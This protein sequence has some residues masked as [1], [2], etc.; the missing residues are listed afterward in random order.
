MGANK[1]WLALTDRAITEVV[2][3]GLLHHVAEDQ[4]LDGRSVSVDG[5]PLINFSL[6]SYLGLEMDARLK[7]GVIDAVMRYGTQFSASRAYLAVAMY[8]ELESLL[9][10]IFGGHVLVT[11]TTTLGHIA[12][13][14]VIVDQN[15]AVILD[16]MVHNSVQT[17]AAL[18]SGRG[19]HV[20]NIPHSAMDLLEE[21]IIE[22][23]K[24]HD[25]VWYLA[26]GVYSMFG[27]VAPLPAL[28][29]LLDRYPQ[30]HL[31]CDD[32]H[33]M[34]WSGKHGCGYA[35]SVQP[36]RDRMI[37]TTSLNKAFSA[38]GGAL[39]FPDA[40]MRR[41][42]RTCGGPMVFSGPIQPPMLGAA[43]ASARIHLSDDIHP[44]QQALKER[45]RHWNRLVQRYGLPQAVNNETPIQFV[46]IGPSKATY[47]ATKRVMEE[48]FLTNVSAFPIVPLRQAG[49]RLT[50]TLHHTFEDIERLAQSLACNLELVGAL[51]SVLEDS[52]QGVVAPTSGVAAPS[53]EPEITVAAA[54]APLPT[55]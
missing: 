45:I 24:T 35:L 4:V 55:R 16:Q 39:I 11:P 50:L 5:K 41:K 29:D 54:S 3:L 43:L 15:D 42:V 49:I 12:A 2:E 34:S 27:D 13:L 19:T 32:A 46:K 17:A 7:Q 37:V 47:A 23:S 26:D 36:L 28:H 20:E 51:D 6:C 1:N 30:F 52:P 33:G 8:D 10:E 44:L 53:A 9:G 14:P 25:R 48:G 40:E 38:A 21:R 22:L 18:L 31:Y